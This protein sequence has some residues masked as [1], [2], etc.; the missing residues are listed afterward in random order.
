MTSGTIGRQASSYRQG[1]VLG[2]TMA[3]IMLLLVFCSAHRAWCRARRRACPTRSGRPTAAP[4]ASGGGR[5]R[6]CDGLRQAQ[7]AP[8]GAARPG[9]DGWITER[10]RR[11]VAQARRERRD[12]RLAGRPRGAAAGA[13]GG[14]RGLCRVS[15]AAIEGH[16][17]G[18][19]RQGGGAGVC[20]RP[21][22]S[23]RWGPTYAGRACGVDRTGDVRIRRRRS[24]AIAGTATTGHRSSI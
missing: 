4:C 2:L 14:G 22:P 24:K 19:G 11:A 16:R 17:S 10:H 15:A 9:R 6:G 18:Q 21:Y 1:M 20:H 23:R 13:Q 12:R 7:H 8:G 3:E 5:R